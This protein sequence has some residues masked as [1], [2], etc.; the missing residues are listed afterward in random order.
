MSRANRADDGD[1]ALIGDERIDVG[2]GLVEVNGVGTGAVL[3]VTHVNLQVDGE[4]AGG[5][6]LVDGELDR[7]GDP[8]DE[9]ISSGPVKGKVDA[10][11]PG[12]RRQ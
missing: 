9:L 5:V 7:V 2:K 11:R 3:V 1:D 6:R 8:M 4:V 10:D 12:A